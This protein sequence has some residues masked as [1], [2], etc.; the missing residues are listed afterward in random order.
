MRLA[1]FPL[2]V[3]ALLQW[4][5]I[6][7]VLLAAA[8]KTDNLYI[9]VLLAFDA[10]VFLLYS[11]YSLR[12]GRSP[13]P[14]RLPRDFHIYSALLLAASLFL[15]FYEAWG[16][17]VGYL[18]QFLTVKPSVLALLWLGG[19]LLLK[20]HKNLAGD[21][22]LFGATGTTRTVAGVFLP[23][24][25]LFLAAASDRPLLILPG[26]LIMVIGW[27]LPPANG[28]PLSGKAANFTLRV[29]RHLLRPATISLITLCGLF[30]IFLF[31]EMT[32][33]NFLGPDRPV[34][35]L[36]LRQPWAYNLARLPH[37]G[38]LVVTFPHQDQLL[39]LDPHRPESY[40]RL[41]LPPSTDRDSY[42]ALLAW[43]ASQ[44]RDSLLL[45]AIRP[46]DGA[47]LRIFTFTADGAGWPRPAGEVRLFHDT[48]VRAPVSFYRE[49]EKAPPGNKANGPSTRI[50]GLD[51]ENN[52]LF[53]FTPDEGVEKTLPLPGN[54][55]TVLTFGPKQNLVF[56]RYAYSP[57]QSLVDW[58]RGRLLR[59]Y[60][61]TGGFWRRLGGG[62]LWFDSRRNRV[63][64]T[65]FAADEMVRV[66]VKGDRPDFRLA[67]PRGPRQIHPVHD[68]DGRVI[69]LAVLGYYG[70][71]IGFYEPGTGRELARAPLAGGLHDLLRVDNHLFATSRQGLHRLPVPAKCR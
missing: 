3:L 5:T 52:L 10:G 30:N 2:L 24:V 43:S 46:G 41:D 13:R 65:L 26:L 38:W 25:I 68:Q 33:D 59:H 50:L 58:Q 11:V 19:L 62:G 70:G 34:G 54:I 28:G 44:N 22:A 27:R 4:L 12:W 31:P 21:R 51:E 42:K 17:R 7:L 36:V 9:P 60:E 69:C 23:L 67:T 29:G 37:S 66:P 47:P 53:T 57:H 71:E 8:A 18:R 45:G 6:A 63:W 1:L 56:V 32:R 35:Q 15:A 16:M 14:P 48:R 20:K 55:P 40:Y 39:L 61:L 49:P 64:T